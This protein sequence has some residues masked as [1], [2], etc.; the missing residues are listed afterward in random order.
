MVRVWSGWTS[1][2]ALGLV[3][4]LGCGGGE[5]APDAG[6]GDAGRVMADAATDGGSGDED[7]ALPDA[8]MDARVEADAGPPDED[9]GPPGY[10]GDGTIDEGEACDDGDANDDA[11]PD[12]CRTD[13][14]AP[15]CGDGVVD[16]A[17]QC[18]T[19]PARSDLLADACRSDCRLPRC[20]D[21]IVDTGEACDQGLMN[22]D[23]A[24]DACRTDCSLPTCGD[25]TVDEGEE[26]DTGDAR[27][28]T[29][30]LACRTD[31]TSSTCGDGLLDEGE[32]CD[33]G[34]ENADVANT[35]RT[36][37]RLPRCGDGIV[38]HR[39]QCDGAS[40]CLPR[41]CVWDGTGDPPVPVEYP[42]GPRP[43]PAC[44]EATPALCAEFLDEG[45]AAFNERV[46][47]SFRIGETYPCW[48]YYSIACA[49]CPYWTERDCADPGR[50]PLACR[51]VGDALCP[52]LERADCPRDVT[53][54]S[55]A[56][57]SYRYQRS[58]LYDPVCRPVVEPLCEALAS[59]SCPA[60]VDACGA[61]LADGTAPDGCAWYLQSRCEGVVRDA[62]PA[63]DT[64]TCSDVGAALAGRPAAC[65][66]Y[67]M[68]RCAGWEER[69][70]P[71]TSLQP[72]TADLCA[73]SYGVLTSRYPSECHAW[74]EAECRASVAA[75]AQDVAASAAICPS[76][77]ARL[78]SGGDLDSFD[79]SLSE[80]G[81]HDCPLYAYEPGP[82]ALVPFA[83]T[84]AEVVVSDADVGEYEASLGTRAVGSCDEYVDQAF[85]SYEVY[86][87]YTEQFYDDARRVYQLAYSEDEEL[88][89]VAIARRTLRFGTPFGYYP[90]HAPVLPG[91]FAL[92]QD[93]G[94]S[95]KNDFY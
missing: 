51:E 74:L 39:E 89:D 60:D 70:C 93:G 53:L 56:S 72:I 81:R 22:S 48:E 36:T 20:G 10:C 35:C 6:S 52:V 91:D 71:E 4:A 54:G 8:A 68:A 66:D 90:S 16:A 30:P 33:D 92:G 12:A 13:C 44:V 55:C 29:L 76:E 5:D 1:L 14:T 79:A 19:G 9:G 62:C 38:D 83:A 23:Y 78:S 34:D 69:L 28:D 57:P 31:C 7:A 18:D 26:C 15:R 17:E 77:T 88:I 63:I 45:W 3:W 27:S 95:P 61:Y 80:P 41:R 65:T 87:A 59:D 43:A 21:A 47:G 11:A 94:T 75:Q 86:R 2:A 37:C 84:P 46:G 85:H 40:N 42:R 64:T 67:V 82:A 73:T 50:L 32:E 58:P 24:P 49:G 25:G